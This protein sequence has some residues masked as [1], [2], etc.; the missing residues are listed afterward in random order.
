MEI[1]AGVL[2]FFRRTAT[3]GAGILMG[4]LGNVLA[5]NLA[6]DLGEQVY[7]SL[8]FLIAAF[9]LSYDVPR[10]YSLLLKQ[11]F[12]RAE[13]FEPVFTPGLVQARIVL[14]SIFV[15]FIFIFGITAYGNFRNFPYLIPQTNG[16]ADS[17]GFYD[18]KEFR[19]NSRL[20]PYSLT[21]SSRWQNVVFEKWATLSIGSAKPVQVDY[22]K[23]ADFHNDDRDRTYEEAG[24][25]QREY[26]SY[27]ADSIKHTLLL[28]NKNPHYKD[29]S[30][31]L[32]YSRP[33]TAT[34][35]LTGID[36][37]GDSLN[38]VLNKVVK[39]YLFYVGRRQPVKF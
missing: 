21:D 15:L 8:L 31:L 28:R 33:D 2:L 3:F 16:L 27:T 32:H 23:A 12:T 35:L 36:R 24:S 30:L 29:D 1:V 39:K 17:Y 11:R 37:R 38:L 22:S 14:R 4:F 6:Y 10:L 20:L 18:V 7:I 5:A 13:R 19:L 34:I 9:L 25:G 26:Y